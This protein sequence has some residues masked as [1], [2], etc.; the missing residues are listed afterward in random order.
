[1]TISRIVFNICLAVL[2]FWGPFWLSLGLILIG[3]LF[4]PYYWESV[5]L[6]FFF[7]LLYASPLGTS[8]MWVIS[9]P[10]IALTFFFVVQHFRK[11][12]Q[13]QLFHF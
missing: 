10:I 9:P 11:V 8:L 4:I 6:F 13:E 12:A 7:E 5:V 1:M 2:L 3:L